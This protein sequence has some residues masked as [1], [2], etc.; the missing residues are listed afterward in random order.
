MINFYKRLQA[1]HFWVVL[2]LVLLGTNAVKAQINTEPFGRNRIQYKRFNWQFL[3]TQNFNVY[4]YDRG[5][6]AA[7]RTAEHAEK[8]LKR[9]TSLIGYFPYS[10]TTIILYSSV[11]DLRQSNIG[12]NED[13]YRTGGESLFLKNKLEIA[14]E[15]TQTEFKKALS[16]NIT[17]LLLNDMMYGGSLKEVLQSSYML[18]LPEWFLSGAAAYIAEGWNVDMDNHMRDMVIKNKSKRTNTWFSPNQPLA[19]Q[20][21]WNYI[22]ERYGYT[23]IQNILNLTRITRDIEVGIA[24][25]LNIP[26]K[27]FM[28]DW[29]QHYITMNTFSDPTLVSLD[30]NNQLFRKNSKNVILT[31][32][33]YSPD[34]KR[35]AYVANDRGRY[36]IK[37]VNVGRKKIHT[38]RKGGYRTPDQKIDY[39]APLLAWKS[40][41]QL[42][43][44][45]VKR[46][47]PTLAVHYFNRKNNAFFA[48]LKFAIFGNGTRGILSQFSQVQNL[49][50]SDDGRMMVMSAVKNGQSDLFLFRGNTRNP[51]QLTKDLYDDKNVAFLKGRNAIVFSSNRWLDSMGT[52]VPKIDRIVD[53]FDLHVMDLSRNGAYPKQLTSSISN[54]F[55]PVPEDEENILY[56]SEE[57]G[58]RSIYRYNLVNGNHTRVTSF[59]QNVKAFDYSGATKNLT[60]IAADRGKEFVY[61]LP[62]FNTSASFNDFKTVRQ[63]TLEE[64]SNRPVAAR[65]NVAKKAPEP[66][67]A[68]EESKPTSDSARA[69]NKTIDPKNYEFEADQQK[70]PA[71]ERPVV[72]NPAP[73]PVAEEMHIDGPIKYD[74]RFSINKV[75]SSINQDA[76]MGFGTIFQVGMSDMFE[77]HRINGGA[78][79][80]T[81]LKTSNFFGEYVNLKKRYDVH[82]SFRK[83]A[84]HKNFTNGPVRYS[85]NEFTPAISYPLTHSISVR[86]LPRLLHT[87]YSTSNIPEPDTVDVFASVGGELVYDNSITTG[88]NMYEG[89]RMKAGISTYKDLEGTN[90]NFGF[91]YLDLR[92]YQKIH[93]LIVW[94]NRLSY[95]QSFGPAAKPYL[96]GGVDN[97]LF[98]KEDSDRSSDNPR[99]NIFR[100]QAPADLFYQQFATP[101]RGFDYNARNGTKQILWNSEIRL[102][103]VQYLFRNDVIGSGFFRNLQLTAFSDIGSAY[104]GANP[105]SRRNSFNTQTV[106]GRASETSNN[107][108]EATVVNYRNPFLFGY[109]AGVRTTL[110]GL[111]GKLDVAWGEE[112]FRRKGPKFYLSL[113][114]DF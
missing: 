29:Q 61:N 20:S 16:L 89:T 97:W 62:N 87:R 98:N 49:D 88:V 92:H 102:P 26:Y 7:Q 112:N 6:E 25:S 109:G 76:I 32:P 31:Q 75:I 65:Q 27:K 58:I 100:N 34:G 52:N 9:I 73:A 56:L 114:Y 71:R 55:A 5:K 11:A 48:N 24:S 64:R 21:V 68:P 85:R 39:K 40:N 10:K 78:F 70:Q 69:G 4:Y 106:G 107:P 12:L 50:Y 81:D 80:V 91:L 45:E 15:G 51:E 94:A 84:V 74:L 72:A 18:R 2:L 13:Q 110:L 3:S 86:L 42:N 60:L 108:F 44:I 105:F 37:V 90:K 57:S 77:D 8:E 93:R 28:R 63:K 113:G 35:V 43:I 103:I 23:S 38:I 53:N 36:E 99:T 66:T 14:F 33:A 95:G 67:P 17:K 79:I 47:Q 54:E 101:M 30:K 96:L 46:A 59:L 19:G 83:Q 104:H 41:Q 111:Y 1:F 82:V 22:S